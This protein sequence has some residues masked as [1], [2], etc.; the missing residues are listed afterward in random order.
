MGWYGF[1][2][3]DES[4]T[5]EGKQFMDKTVFYFGRSQRY[6]ICVH[7]TI[8]FGI[9]FARTKSSMTRARTQLLISVETCAVKYFS[10][11]T[12]RTQKKQMKI[13]Q[14]VNAV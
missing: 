10:N 5:H 9:W 14:Y 6:P 8:Q 11:P 3:N 12:R 2:N 4:G 7:V 1:V 13:A